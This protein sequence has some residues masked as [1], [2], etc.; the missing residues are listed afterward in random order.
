VTATDVQATF[1]SLTRARW[2]LPNRVGLL[3]THEV[4]VVAPNRLRM[5]L[6]R[7]YGP[8]LSAWTDLP[9]LPATWW[10]THECQPG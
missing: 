7:Q 8:A 10:K 3:A 4:E 9:I 2:P 6:W 5:A 1:E